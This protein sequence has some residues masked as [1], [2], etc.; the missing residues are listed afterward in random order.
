V[1]LRMIWDGSAQIMHHA[2]MLNLFG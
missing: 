2:A 1:A